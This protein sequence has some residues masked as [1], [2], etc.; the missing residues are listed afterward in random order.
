MKRIAAA[1]FAAMLLCASAPAEVEYKIYDQD[2]IEQWRNQHN[3]Q[4]TAEV[5]N[6]FTFVIPAS[7]EMECDAASAQL[8]VKVSKMRVEAGQRL[9]V[10]IETDG[11]LKSGESSIPF[12]LTKDGNAVRQLDFS[13][14]GTQQLQVN[15]S[16]EAWAGAH[17]GDCAGTVNFSVRIQSDN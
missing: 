8:P 5:T 7:I 17:A 13:Q 9:V 4:I 12:T 16:P 3:F 15:V 11:M 2:Q 1:L 14:K 6:G 10:S